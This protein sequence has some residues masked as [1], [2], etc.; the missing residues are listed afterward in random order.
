MREQEQLLLQ[1]VKNSDK[2]AFQ[3][4]FS[5]FYDTLYRFV[6]YRIKDADLADDITQETFLIIGC[7]KK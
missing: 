1:Q 6:I 7:E 3:Q 2:S 5:N 4:L